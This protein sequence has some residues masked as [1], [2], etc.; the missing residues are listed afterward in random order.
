[1]QLEE[2]SHSLMEI[3]HSFNDETIVNKIAIKKIM[4]KY[5]K[6]KTHDLIGKQI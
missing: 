3:K 1:M 2:E 6:V 4:G 5:T